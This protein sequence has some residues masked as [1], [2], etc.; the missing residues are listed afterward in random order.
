MFLGIY[1]V[2]CQQHGH[3]AIATSSGWSVIVAIDL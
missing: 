1:C 3:H 2:E